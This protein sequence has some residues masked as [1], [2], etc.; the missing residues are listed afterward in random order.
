MSDAPTLAV[1][2][3][4]R[5]RGLRAR[6]APLLR[7]RARAR[8]RRREP[9]RLSA[10]RA[11]RPERRRQ[12]VAARA[13]PSRARCAGSRRSRSSSSSRVGATTRRRALAEAVGEAAGLSTNGSVVDCAR[14]GSVDARRLPRPRPSRGV[15]PLPRGRRRAGVVRRGAAG[16]ARGA[17]SRVNVLVSLRED[18]LAQAR[19]L[20][21][22]H[23]GPLREHA[24][25][26][27]LDRAAARGGDRATGRALRGA[28]GRGGDRRAALVERVLDEVGSGPDRAGARRPRRRRG[29]ARRRADRGAVPPAR[30]AAALGGGARRGLER[31][32]RSRRSSGSA[33]R[34]RSSRSISRARWPS[35]RRS[36]RTSRRGSSTTSSRRRARRSPTRSPIW[37]TSARSRRRVQPGARRRWPSAGSCARSR[38]AAAFATRSS[39]T[40]SRS[41]CSRGARAIA[42][43]VRSSEQVEE[44]ARRGRGCQRLARSRGRSRGGPRGGSWLSRSRSSRTRTRRARDAHARQLDASAIALL[45]EDPEL[46]LLLAR[47]SARLAPGP[48]AEDALLQS[49]LTSRV[50]AT[51]SSG[52]PITGA[53]LSPRRRHSSRMSTRPACSSCPRRDRS[54]GFDCSRSV[55]G[56]HVVLSEDGHSFAV[57]RRRPR[58]LEWSRPSANGALRPRRRGG[59][60]A[61]ACPPEVASSWFGTALGR[62]GSARTCARTSLGRVG[63]T[64]VRLVVSPDGTRVAF[65]LRA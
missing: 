23:S 46:S 17:A 33:A 43:S 10:D 58:I 5:V 47:E 38:R 54:H 9:H 61:D 41:R 39:T 13:P 12:V 6:R 21:G 31:A 27:P 57:V 42:P 11:L 29:R 60:A 16:G 36:R 14:A 19:P 59:S 44:R 30:D 3:A 49:L 7:A 32:A 53:S 51:D 24:S 35:S 1:Q 20:H 40:F 2:G 15:L 64:A 22:P 4:Q 18:S 37:P 45:T 26:R 56:A 52:G 34:S 63:Q 28:H 48:T 50:R 62:S 8:D 65:C 25:P 55:A